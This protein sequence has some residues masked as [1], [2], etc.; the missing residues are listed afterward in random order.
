MVNPTYEEVIFTNKHAGNENADYEVMYPSSRQTDAHSNETLKPAKMM[1]VNP[2]YD[3]AYFAN[4]NVANVDAD[5]E[6][7]HPHTTQ[8]N[9]NNITATTN[10]AYTEI[11]L[12]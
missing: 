7:M 12:L 5:Y 8:T 1:A 4:T 2:V 6:V 11:E 3:G 9:A 10:A